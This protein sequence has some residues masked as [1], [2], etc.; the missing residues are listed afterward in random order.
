MKIETRTENKFNQVAN[1]AKETKRDLT[2]LD[3]LL[4]IQRATGDIVKHITDFAVDAVDK[5]P[6]HEMRSQYMPKILIEAAHMKTENK[7]NKLN[8]DLKFVS[9]V[10]T[11]L[12]E[13]ID[14]LKEKYTSRTEFEREI[15]QFAV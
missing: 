1:K 12:D 15:R 7:I 11:K 8:S 5:G 9:A 4:K 2:E 13:R 10:C 14:G 3:D 6:I